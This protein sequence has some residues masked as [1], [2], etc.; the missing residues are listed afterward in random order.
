[1]KKTLLL[2]TTILFSTS[3]FADTAV[4]GQPH[5]PNALER[6]L[7]IPITKE[8]LTTGTQRAGAVIL[9]NKGKVGL[10]TLAVGGVVWYNYLINHPE[11]MSE[12]FAVHPDLLDKFTQY[13]DYRIEHAQSQEEY[14]TFTNVKQKL[15]LDIDQ[16]VAD[17]FAVENDPM[18]KSLE[19]EVRD[20]IQIVDTALVQNNQM[21]NYCNVNVISQLVIPRKQFENTIN[22]ISNNG[23]FVGLPQIQSVA[24]QTS[25]LDVNTF[26]R[27]KD[28]YKKSSKVLELEQDHI[29]S[30]AAIDKYLND[31]GITTKTTVKINAK[32]LKE[33]I[34]D[35]ELEGNATAIST[36]YA[37]HKLG[38]TFAG[39]NYKSKVDKDSKN[40]LEATIKDIA[41]TAYWFFRNNQYNITAQD[42][43]KSAMYIYVRNKMLCIYDVK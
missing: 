28:G 15:A 21:P 17:D 36:P 8:T 10:G 11:K 16:N 5:A 9:A 12:F 14:D 2:A 29:P 27:L 4:I 41:T 43:I 33:S 38:R 35:L 34:R 3:V 20:E 23:V 24:N 13:V 42:Y 39:R 7:S 40:L 30:F 6:F 26:K 37:I 1:M 19:N 25:I 31:H 22:T 18:Y 32:G